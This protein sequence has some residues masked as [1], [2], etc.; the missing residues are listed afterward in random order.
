MNKEQYLAN[1]EGL[2]SSLSFDERREIM[3]DYEAHFENALAEGESEAEV[4]AALNKPEIVAAHYVTIGKPKPILGQKSNTIPTTMARDL[5]TIKTRPL[6]SNSIE[7]MPFA[8]RKGNSTPIMIV[9][10]FLL[11]VLTSMVLS[12][13]VVFWAV[14]LSCFAI[15]LATLF[16]GFALLI[17]TLVSTP[18]A[19][20]GLNIVAFEHPVFVISVSVGLLSIGGLGLIASYFIGRG[21][22]YLAYYYFR[23]CFKLVRGY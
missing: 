2:L 9:I 5:T 21:L 19:L 15:A 11:L 14:L 10:I 7:S 4:I 8:Q 17:S 18:M 6:L 13:Y 23:W 20:F 1:L 22:S 12:P 3:Y 16:G